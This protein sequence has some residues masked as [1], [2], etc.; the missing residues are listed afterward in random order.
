MND[1]T[2]TKLLSWGHHLG[3]HH[4]DTLWG[5][6]VISWNF[7]RNFVVR[8]D[9]T[10]TCVGFRE[11]SRKMSWPNAA[12]D[13]WFWLCRCLGGMGWL[14]RLGSTCLPIEFCELWKLCHKIC[15]RRCLQVTDCIV[16]PEED[17]SCYPLVPDSA[18]WCQWFSNDT[19]VK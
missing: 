18:P 11:I 3:K 17:V 10:A 9:W 1:Y 8:V 13:P 14:S 12:L 6:H 19:R 5:F 16:Q 4:R 15:R 7:G 2:L